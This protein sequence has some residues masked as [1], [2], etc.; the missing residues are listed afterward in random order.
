MNRVEIGFITFACL[1]FVFWCFHMTSGLPRTISKYTACWKCHQR[2][3]WLARIQRADGYCS[4]KC[5]RLDM[6]YFNSLGVE[7]LHDDQRDFYV[8]HLGNIR[9][10]NEKK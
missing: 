4:Y 1:M 7:R 3:S 6:Q 5:Q 8:N 9:R 2:L 10:T